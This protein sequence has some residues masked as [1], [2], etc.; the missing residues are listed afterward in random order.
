MAEQNRLFRLDQV[1]TPEMLQKLATFE[2]SYIKFKQVANTL[3]KPRECSF[4]DLVYIEYLRNAGFLDI[5]V[6]MLQDPAF[7]KQ[8][9]I[10]LDKAIAVLQWLNLALYGDYGWDGD[11]AS[12]GIYYWLTE[13]Q[14]PEQPLLWK[15]ANWLDQCVYGRQLH[16]HVWHTL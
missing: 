7:E 8:H 15:C 10:F 4:T 6:A 5:Y 1:E 9:A 11:L 2:A 13:T 12:R 16:Q 3:P 14:Q